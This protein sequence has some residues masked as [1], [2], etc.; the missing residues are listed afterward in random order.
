M[1]PHQIL[2]LP[3]AKMSTVL[4]FDLDGTLYD[5]SNGYLQRIRANIFRMMVEKGYGANE[6]EAHDIW[7]PLFKKHN[8]TF[9]GLRESGYPFTADEYWEKHRAGIE[10]YFSHDQPL[11]DLLNALPQRKVIFTNCR[12]KEA[13]KIMEL[14]GIDD[15][16]EA[17]Y[18]SDFMGNTCKPQK[19]SFEAL[20]HAMNVKP[21]QIVFFEDS[22][23]NLLTAQSLGM[24]CVLVNS[25]TAS[26]EGTVIVPISEGSSVCNIEGFA[27]PVTVVTSLSD[28]GV[29]LRVALP[30]LFAV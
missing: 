26:E 9:K 29:Q 1:S 13:I 24:Q 23:K 21:E 11:V 15:C 6:Q 14:L 18:G 20:F 27:K 28:G 25:P 7:K 12:E 10:E 4:V 8:Q 5:I 3:H 17:V 16:F 2:S 19:E 30:E 22:V